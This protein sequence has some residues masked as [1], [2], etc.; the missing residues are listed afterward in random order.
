MSR[1]AVKVEHIPV[2]GP[3]EVI[4]LLS[5]K[6]RIEALPIKWKRI[7]LDD[8]TFYCPSFDGWRKA[9]DYLMPKVPKYIPER[10]DCE[11]MACWFYVHLCEDFR[12]NTMARVQGFAIV[13]GSNVME[14]HAWNIFTD[15]KYFYQLEPQT[16]VLMD[17]DDPDYIP[18]EIVVG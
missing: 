11:F 12:V 7:K 18:D 17:I 16:G 3:E 14:R 13:A 5:M 2:L 9:I 15:G 4:S 10:R 6:H 1:L 8:H